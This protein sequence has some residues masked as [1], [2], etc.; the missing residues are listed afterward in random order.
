MPPVMPWKYRSVIQAPFFSFVKVVYN[1]TINVPKIDI[2]SSHA[3]LA[4]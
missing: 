3:K 1:P 4:V 2:V